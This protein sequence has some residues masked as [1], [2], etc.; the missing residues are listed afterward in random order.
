MFFLGAC[1]AGFMLEKA[2]T[3]AKEMKYGILAFICIF[4]MA[5]D[6]IAIIIYLIIKAVQML[7]L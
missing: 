5:V 1:F 3:T 4:G 7:P 6:I 2:S